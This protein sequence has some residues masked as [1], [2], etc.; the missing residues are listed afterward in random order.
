MAIFCDL[1]KTFDTI[2]HLRLLNKLRSL[3]VTG[4]ALEFLTSYLTGKFQVFI[5]GDDRS[6]PGGISCGVPRGSVRGPLLFLIYI[7]ALHDMRPTAKLIT[8][9]DDAVL[10]LSGKDP[11]VI[12]AEATEAITRTSSWMRTNGLVLNAKKT[13]YML[14]AG[15]VTPPSFDLVSHQVTK[16]LQQS[17]LQLPN[18]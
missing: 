16:R 14:F 12:A 15:Q 6:E 8:F 1:S 13:Q 11:G 5:D 4:L 7:N 10:L 9:A 18:D 17:R 3:G 2:D